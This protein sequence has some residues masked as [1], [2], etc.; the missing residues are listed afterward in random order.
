[1]KRLNLS[2][3]SE[4]LIGF[5]IPRGGRFYVCDHDEVWS[6]HVGP[7]IL[8]E[9]S[10]LQPYD[11]AACDDFVGWGDEDKSPVLLHNETEIRYCF[12]PKQ[13]HVT[14]EISIGGGTQQINFLTFSGDWFAASLSADGRHLVLAEPYNLEIYEID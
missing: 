10:D 13:P 1:M 5:T 7:P 4:R 6:V 8:L 11:V 3:P 14:V 2:V 9:N 12:D